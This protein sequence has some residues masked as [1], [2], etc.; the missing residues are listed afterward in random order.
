MLVY[1]LSYSWVQTCL[2]H[3][4]P[5]QPLLNGPGQPFGWGYFSQQYACHLQTLHRL[6][7]H[8]R[9]GQHPNK[10]IGC[11]SVLISWEGYLLSSCCCR[12][13]NWP[14]SAINNG[15]SGRKAS[16]EV[17]LRKL[18]NSIFFWPYLNFS[19]LLGH[20]LYPG[21]K[22]IVHFELCNFKHSTKLKISYI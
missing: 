13:F 15:S 21:N 3:Q 18:F 11:I 7:K 19:P 20:E 16:F 2:W 17:S 9:Q 5:Y 6:E 22:Y 8:R 4:N 14:F 10:H 1:L 12:L